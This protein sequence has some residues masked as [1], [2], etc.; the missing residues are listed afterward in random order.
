MI[1]LGLYAIGVGILVGILYAHASLIP[2]I[3][4][5]ASSIAGMLGG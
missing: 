5:V 4:I 3:D 1:K 2:Y